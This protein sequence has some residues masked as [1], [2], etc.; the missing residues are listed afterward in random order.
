MLSYS[1]ILFTWWC[2]SAGV[3]SFGSHIA[4]SYDITTF[5]IA[6]LI[7]TKLLNGISARAL[8]P[9]FFHWFAQP[10]KSGETWLDHS[11]MNVCVDSFWLLRIRNIMMTKKVTLS[12]Q[13]NLLTVLS[14]KILVLLFL[15]GQKKIKYWGDDSS[16]RL[17]RPWFPTPRFIHN[18]SHR[19]TLFF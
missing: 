2:C 19:Q 18:L 6:S 4:L 15:K 7:H 8:V 12:F 1:K 11:K 16:E 14:E 9:N 5:Y 10:F 17:W 13:A 3:V